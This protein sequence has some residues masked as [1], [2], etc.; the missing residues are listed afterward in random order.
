MPAHGAGTKENGRAG[1]RSLF[2]DDHPGWKAQAREITPNR[3]RRSFDFG[4]G[5]GVK[6]YKFPIP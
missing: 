1:A 5:D 3:D 2:C 6:N 4:G